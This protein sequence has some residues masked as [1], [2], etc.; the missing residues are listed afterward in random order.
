MGVCAYF[1]GRVVHGF[2]FLP[3]SVIPLVRRSFDRLPPSQ[4]GETSLFVRT[5][6]VIFIE[7]G[8]EIVFV[9]VRS[10]VLLN[11]ISRNLRLHP[12]DGIVRERELQ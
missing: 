2:F 8:I 10:K 9:L 12:C 3:H 7:E 6:W 11:N 1:T 5:L 4:L